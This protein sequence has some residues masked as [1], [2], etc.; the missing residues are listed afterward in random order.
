MNSCRQAGLGNAVN[1]L[2][3]FIFITTSRFPAIFLPLRRYMPP[4]SPLPLLLASRRP[5]GPATSRRVLHPEPALTSRCPH[6]ELCFSGAGC[7]PPAL[8]S[9]WELVKDLDFCVR[10]P[11]CPRLTST[12]VPPMASW[13][14][15]V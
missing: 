2:D 15:L 14:Y 4:L 3:L 9:L 1:Y 7:G 6:P 8:R 11:H 12:G 10:T 5:G 13:K